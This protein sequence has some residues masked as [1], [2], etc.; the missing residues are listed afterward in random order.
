MSYNETVSE[1]LM[2]DNATLEDAARAFAQLIILRVKQG[3][4]VIAIDWADRHG[5]S[6]SQM[7]K[8]CRTGRIWAKLRPTLRGRQPQ[9]MWWIDP[10][11]AAE[12][13]ALDPAEKNRRSRRENKEIS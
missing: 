5:V 11:E 3:R 2:A 6:R 12:Y 1:R 10:K 8:W 4:A 7:N 13:A 9:D